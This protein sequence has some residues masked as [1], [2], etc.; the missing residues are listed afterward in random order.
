[1]EGY[2]LSKKTTAPNVIRAN[3]RNV[4][5]TLFAQCLTLI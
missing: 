4:G 1:M 2:F 5:T 3:A